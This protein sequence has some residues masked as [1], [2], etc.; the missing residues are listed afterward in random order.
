[1]GLL[2]VGLLTIAVSLALYGSVAFVGGKVKAPSAGLLRASTAQSALPMDAD[3]VLDSS[4][5]TALAVST[6]GW[7]ANIA[8]VVVPVTF[9]ITLYLQS[10][11][12]KAEDG[13]DGIYGDGQ[14]RGIPG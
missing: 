2:P 14:F 10:E 7:W 11:R 3:L 8:I 4:L 1:M 12:T 6:P 5:T 13:L 9:L